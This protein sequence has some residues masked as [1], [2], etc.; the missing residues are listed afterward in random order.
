MTADGQLH[1]PVEP[2]PRVRRRSDAEAVAYLRAVQAEADGPGPVAPGSD[3]ERWR[4][5]DA[6]TR[7]AVESL[8]RKAFPSVFAGPADGGRA[9]PLV[10]LYQPG[11]VVWVM[12]ESGQVHTYEV[13]GGGELTAMDVGEAYDRL[14]EHEARWRAAWMNQHPS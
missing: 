3:A 4:R 8:V 14:G 11:D 10:T 9:Q 13:G 5:M 1:G 7:A 6:E 12:A 2:P